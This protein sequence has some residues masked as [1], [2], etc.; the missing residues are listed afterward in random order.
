M[1]NNVF[2]GAG[3]NCRAVDVNTID[4]GNPLLYVRGV[5]HLDH[6]V[7]TFASELGYDDLMQSFSSGRMNGFQTGVLVLPCKL[8]VKCEL[9][10]FLPKHAAESDSPGSCKH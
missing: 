2:Q 4:G 3:S 9:R 6:N 1:S 8:R 5:F 10:C 7:L